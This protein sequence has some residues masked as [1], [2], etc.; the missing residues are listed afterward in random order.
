MN[1]DVAQM[2]GARTA[3]LGD[4]EHCWMAQDPEATVEGLRRF[5]ASLD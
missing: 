5:W 2:L 1:L 4:L 3:S